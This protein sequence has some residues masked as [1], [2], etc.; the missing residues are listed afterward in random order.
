[1]QAVVYLSLV[2]KVDKCRAQEFGTCQ[3]VDKVYHTVTWLCQHNI[4]A[5]YEKNSIFECAVFLM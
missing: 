2:G 1:M 3:L 5:D 4:W